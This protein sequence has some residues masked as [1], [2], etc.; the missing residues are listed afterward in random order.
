MSSSKK[1]RI[2]CLSGLELDLALAQLRKLRSSV[3]VEEVP[4]SDP[5]PAD[6]FTDQLNSMIVALES[7]TNSPL[8]PPLF[9]HLAYNTSLLVVAL[10]L[11]YR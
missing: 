3:I 2:S 5:T 11:R 1:R 6:T 9:S 4:E 8:V 10:F 7:R